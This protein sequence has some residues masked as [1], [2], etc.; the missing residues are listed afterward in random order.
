MRS[1]H[2]VGSSIFRRSADCCAFKRG[3]AGWGGRMQ[4]QGLDIDV[5]SYSRGRIRTRGERKEH[6]VKGLWVGKRV[7]L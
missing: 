6:C 3:S 4:R 7:L 5:K 2:E 1:T